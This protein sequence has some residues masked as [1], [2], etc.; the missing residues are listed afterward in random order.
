MKNNR[1]IFTGRKWPYWIPDPFNMAIL[2]VC[3]FISIVAIGIYWE[4]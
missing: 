1:N 2:G 3:V 4:G